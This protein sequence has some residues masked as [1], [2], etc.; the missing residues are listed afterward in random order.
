MGTL[1]LHV[2]FK[3]TAHISFEQLCLFL[4]AKQSPNIYLYTVC[5]KALLIWL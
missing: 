4:D 1:V 5:K 3:S 2:G